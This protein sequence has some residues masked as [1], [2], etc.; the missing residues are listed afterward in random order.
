M[1]D[2]KLHS[3]HKSVRDSDMQAR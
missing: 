2:C 1:I 3:A